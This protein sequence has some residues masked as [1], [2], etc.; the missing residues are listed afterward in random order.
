MKTVLFQAVQLRISSQFNFVCSIQRTLSD[1]TTSGQSG[2]LGTMVMKGYSIFPALLKS[3]HQ[4]ISCH[5]QNIC[6]GVLTICREA[7][8]V[9]YCPNRQSKQYVKYR[10][11]DISPSCK[12]DNFTGMQY[13]SYPLTNLPD[14]LI[15][16]WK[17]KVLCYPCESL[18]GICTCVLLPTVMC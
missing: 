8:A 3:Q 6:S 18:I 4:I 15:D 11:N 14:I 2:G 17:V 7:V 16:I 12:S 13:P 1:S 10:P 9:F 5:I